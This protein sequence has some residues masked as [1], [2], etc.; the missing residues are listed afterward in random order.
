MVKMVNLD[1]AGHIS[2]LTWWMRHSV[3]SNFMNLAITWEK[4]F[5]YKP[6]G[7]LIIPQKS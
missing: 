1:K 7:N 6:I 3:Y 5:F 4:Y 2:D